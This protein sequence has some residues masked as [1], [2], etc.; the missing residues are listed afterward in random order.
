MPWLSIARRDGMP[1]PEWRKS[2]WREV[3]PLRHCRE[4]PRCRAEVSTI[5]SQREHWADHLA[6]DALIEK[7]DRAIRKVLAVVRMLATEAGHSDWY[8]PVAAEDEDQEE[9]GEAPPLTGFVIGSGELPPGTRGG[10]D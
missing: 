6:T 7:M 3:D 4:C 9:P 5:P 2:D 8:P 1:G 10:E